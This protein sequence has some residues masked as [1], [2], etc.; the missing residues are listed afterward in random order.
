MFNYRSTT[1]TTAAV[2]LHTPTT[3]EERTPASRPW[4]LLCPFLQYMH[5]AVNSDLAAYGGTFPVHTHTYQFPTTSASL[6]YYILVPLT[7]T[8]ALLLAEACT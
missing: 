2:E 6:D 4:L 5:N 1:T 8:P 3:A 7:M